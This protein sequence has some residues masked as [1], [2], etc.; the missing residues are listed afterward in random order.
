MFR[1][2]DLLAQMTR[3][4]TDDACSKAEKLR[5]GL[6][7]PSDITPQDKYKARCEMALMDTSRHA[8]LAGPSAALLWEMPLQELPEKVFLR[9]VTRSGARTGIQVFSGDAPAVDLNA[10]RITP[11]ALT[12]VDCARVLSPRDGLI[13]A[14]AALHDGLC[15]LEE[16]REVLATMPRARGIGWARW[17][18][19]EADPLA[20]SPGES[21]TRMVLRD[22]GYEPVSQ[23]ELQSPGFVAYVDF[24]LDDRLGI[25]FDGAGKYRNTGVVVREKV[26]HGQAE[27]CGKLLMRVVWHQLQE[28]ARID[29]RV[30]SYGIAPTRRPRLT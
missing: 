7:V 24:M 12:V 19:A 9:G 15:T 3:Q 1:R 26:R 20:E 28:P 17:V 21:W 22:L 14:D 6:Y 29:R 10:V 16:L 5:R 30:R 8:V 18:V 4:Q 25:E 13:V 23:Y 11:P 2:Q 27:E